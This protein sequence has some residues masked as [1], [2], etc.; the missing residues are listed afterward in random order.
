MDE[1]V[2]NREIDSPEIRAFYTKCGYGGGLD[3]SDE[4]IVARKNGKT[5]CYT[6]NI[7]NKN[8]FVGMKLLSSRTLRKKN[9]NSGPPVGP[10]DI[11]GTAALEPPKMWP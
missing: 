1:I 7:V 2:I 10:V 9:P 4:T 11:L 5:T 3:S 8:W 6:G